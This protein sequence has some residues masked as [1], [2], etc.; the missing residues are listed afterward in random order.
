MLGA[1]SLLQPEAPLRSNCTHA[2]QRTQSERHQRWDPVKM[3]QGSLSKHLWLL[4]SQQ[5]C[6][7]PAEPCST[8][9]LKLQEVQDLTGRIL[10]VPM[11][12]AIK[13][14]KAYAYKFLSLVISCISRNIEFQSHTKMV[15]SL[16]YRAS[17][18]PPRTAAAVQM[19]WPAMPPNATPA[20]LDDAARP[21]KQWRGHGSP[22]HH[23]V[24]CKTGTM[25]RAGTHGRSTL[26]SA[27]SHHLTWSG[28]AEGLAN[29]LAYLTVPDT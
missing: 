27:S 12:G 15:R 16:M 6:Y 20:A 13:A 17:W 23:D 24:S 14:C 10:A 7:K 29:E 4:M 2:V 19:A 1:C 22:Q 21:G 11:I 18:R 26:E 3:H 28:K 25:L 9:S 5:P 8:A